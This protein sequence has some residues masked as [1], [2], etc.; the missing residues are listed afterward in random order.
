MET[1]V[2]GSEKHWQ[3]ELE[4]PAQRKLIH[5]TD[6]SY[7]PGTFMQEPHGKH[8]VNPLANTLNLVSSN[9][10][11]QTTAE[12]DSL[13]GWSYLREDRPRL[14]FDVSSRSKVRT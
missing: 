11:F 13:L 3:E 5:H 10:T 1:R 2:N 7:Y 9:L 8:T 4:A 14:K 6:I 12:K